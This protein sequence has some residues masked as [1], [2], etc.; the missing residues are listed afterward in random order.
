[1]F[2]K[3]CR[4]FIVK[5]YAKEKIELFI[6][7]WRQR[8]FTCHV[9]IF[10]L[11][12]VNK[13][14]FVIFL[15]V[16][17]VT[18]TFHYSHHISTCCTTKY[19]SIRFVILKLRKVIVKLLGTNTCYLKIFAF[20]STITINSIIFFLTSVMASKI[21]VKWDIRRSEMKRRL[22]RNLGGKHYYL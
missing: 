14:F 11:I 19:L 1:M 16:F 18:K 6:H 15:I 8:Y 3:V 7:Q 4:V 9:F 12:T 20:K 17:F 21:L 10:C 22:R 5:K 13:S 2:S